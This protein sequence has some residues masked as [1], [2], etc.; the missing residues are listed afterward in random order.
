M[1]RKRAILRRGLNILELLVVVALIAVILGLLAPALSSVRSAGRSAA[2]QSNLRQLAFAAQSYAATYDVFP[3]ALRYEDRDGVFVQ[4]AWDWVTTLAG[5]L[6]EPGPLWSFTDNP[7]EVQQCPAYDGGSNFTGDPFSGYN[8]NTTYVGGEALFPNTG[9]DKVRWGVRPHA[10]NRSS[11][12]AMFGCG[13]YAG[14]AN[15]FMRA[16]LNSEAFALS[17]IYSGGQAFRHGGACNIVFLDT[18]VDHVNRPHRGDLATDELLT[19][20]L[21]YPKNGFLSDDDAAYDPR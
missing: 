20:F 3:T 14:G 10:C 9:W 4:V 21:D 8:Y 2:C 15:K 19:A 5:D 1:N 16:P 7:D 13:G 12:C 18:H 17:T 6:I 11:T